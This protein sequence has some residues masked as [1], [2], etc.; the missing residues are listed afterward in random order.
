MGDLRARFHMFLKRA[1]NGMRTIS[2]NV[3]GTHR[4]YKV[5]TSEGNFVFTI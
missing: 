3:R 2:Y 5:L 4:A 1:I